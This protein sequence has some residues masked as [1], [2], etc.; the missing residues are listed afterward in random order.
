[1]MFMDSESERDVHG[2]AHVK[3]MFMDSESDVHGQ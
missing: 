3:V 1:M 2:D